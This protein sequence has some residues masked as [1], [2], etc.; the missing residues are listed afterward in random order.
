MAILCMDRGPQT[1]VTYLYKYL[2]GHE[3]L[4]SIIGKKSIPRKEK[5]ENKS[6][7]TKGKPLTSIKKSVLRKIMP[8]SSMTKVWKQAQKGKL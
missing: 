2:Y 8:A 3:A 5:N 4:S 7:S 1:D 6:F